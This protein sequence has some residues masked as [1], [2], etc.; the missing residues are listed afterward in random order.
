MKLRNDLVLAQQ[1]AEKLRTAATVNTTLAN[2]SE[3]TGSKSLAE[4][5]AEHVATLR[6]ELEARYE[7]RVQQNDEAFK[8]KGKNMSTQL[9]EKLREGKNKFRQELTAEHEQAVQKLKME[10]SQEIEKIQAQ[11]KQ[12]MEELKRI[13]EARIAEVKA[14]PPQG[15]QSQATQNGPTEV[16]SESQQDSSAWQP[17]EQD[18]R[19]LIQSNEFLK[20][21]LRSNITKQINKSKEELTAQLKGQQEKA[22][23]DMQTRNEAAKEHAIALAGKKSQLQLN[24]ATNKVKVQDFKLGIVSKAAQ[25]TPQ[26]AVQEVWTLVKDA[27]PPPAPTAGPPATS[28]G[29]QP[30]QAATKVATPTASTFGQ[31][32]PAVQPPSANA[33]PHQQPVSTST[34][35]FGKPTPANTGAQNQ[36]Q[37]PSTQSGQ[38][39]N[40]A[41][42]PPQ[43]IPSAPQQSGQPSTSSNTTTP[44]GQSAPTQTHHPGSGPGVPRGAASGIPR[45]G[46][47][48]GNATAR[49]GPNARGR[50]SGIA[51]GAPQSL[52][53]NR[54]AQAANQSKASPSSALSA[55]AKQFV[56]GNKRPSDDPQGGDGKR[57]RGGGGAGGQ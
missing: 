33:A 35:T 26:K 36:N 48:R 49:G 57:V 38:V 56:P 41:I 45:G 40:P 55:G 27:K 32:T 54:A 18:I 9:S 51:R 47:L 23:A 34:A 6:A 17:S 30:Q 44:S 46:S 7:E 25:E 50:G 37:N 14:S 43:T 19:T 52:D 22:I 5:V 29:G 31:P 39:P 8:V 42:Q 24:M 53:T 1:E 20:G 2:A 4:Q 28:G 15:S 16:K 10:Q 11:H 13:E 12:E 21:I 3:E